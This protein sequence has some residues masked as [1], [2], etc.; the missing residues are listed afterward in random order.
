M[1]WTW[2]C[3]RCPPH[4]KALD[5]EFAG[6]AELIYTEGCDFDGNDT[7]KFSEALAVARKAD[8]ILLCM[9]EKKKW[10]GE[11]ASRSIIELPAIQEKFIAEMKKAG[12]PI[13]L[14]LANGRPLGLS[15]VEPLCDAIVEMWQP[16]V[17]GGKPLAGVL[18]GRVNPSGKLSIT[19]HVPPDRFQSITISAKQPVHKVANIKTSPLPH[20]MNSDTA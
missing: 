6:K 10:S 8:V 3:R 20:C 9:G 16:G 14:A 1:V 19:F 17:P 18:S 5:A 15:K 7:S 11:N 12:K 4:Q 2:T 13:V